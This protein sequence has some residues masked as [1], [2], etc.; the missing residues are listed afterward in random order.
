[1]QGSN[2]RNYILQQKLDTALGQV[3]TYLKS[4]KSEQLETQVNTTVAASVEEL[5]AERDLLQK[6]REEAEKN[7]SA[8]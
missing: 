2:S 5:K 7:E 6:Q 8:R 3:E 4:K 1:M